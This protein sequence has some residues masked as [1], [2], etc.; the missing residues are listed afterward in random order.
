MRTG[1]NYYGGVSLYIFTLQRTPLFALPLCAVLPFTLSHLAL[2]ICLRLLFA[3]LHRHTLF[4][5]LQRA[6]CGHADVA[7]GGAEED[8]A[9]GLLAHICQLNNANCAFAHCDGRLFCWF[10]VYRAGVP[11]VLYLRALRLAQTAV[12]ARRLNAG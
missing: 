12:C 4:C 8:D 2:I 5:M 7:Q 11:R 9:G 3:L 10:A 6:A 1:E